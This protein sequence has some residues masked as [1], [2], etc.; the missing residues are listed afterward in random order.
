LS[1]PGL[2]GF[3]GFMGEGSSMAEGRLSLGYSEYIPSLIRVCPE[4][5]PSLYRS[6]VKLGVNLG[7]TV[8]KGEGGCFKLSRKHAVN[9]ALIGVR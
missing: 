5:I 1:E 7:R 6:Q 2:E 3:N 4:Y 8:V 9:R